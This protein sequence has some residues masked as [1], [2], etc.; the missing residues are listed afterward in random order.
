MNQLI[1]NEEFIKAAKVIFSLPSDKTLTKSSYIEEFKKLGIISVDGVV[2]DPDQTISRQ[3]LA[4]YLIYGLG[5]ANDARKV[6]PIT[7][8]SIANVDRVDSSINKFVTLAMQLNI[9]SNQEDGRFHGSDRYVTRA[10]LVEAA[11]EAKKLYASTQAEAPSKVSIAEVKVTGARKVAVTLNKI[12]DTEKAML[13]VK[14]DGTEL[15]GTT[16]WSD[17]RKTATITLD[18]KLKKGSYTIE[19]SGLDAASLD[20]KSAEFTAEDEQFKSLEFV[21]PSDTLARSKVI[22]AFKQTNQYGEQTDLV[23]SRFDI[24]VGGGSGPQNMTNKQEF[25]LDLS[26]ESRGARIP[27][28]LIDREHHVTVSKVFTVGDPAIVSK[29][30]V[31][32]LKY[33]DNKK[34]LQPGNKAYLPIKVYDQYGNRMDDP[35]DWKKGVITLFTGDHLIEEKGQ[36]VFYDFGDDGELEMELEAIPSLT[37]DSTTIL[38]LVA[39]GS[40]QTVLKRISVLTPKKPATLEIPDPPSFLAEGDTNKLLELKIRDAEGREFDPDERAELVKAGKLAVYSSGDLKLGS[41]VEGETG[42]IELSGI[43]KGNIRIQEVLAGNGTAS[44]E[45]K[46]TDIQQS[47]TAKIDLMP[48][49]VPKTLEKS[50]FEPSL[51]YTVIQGKSA[52]PKFKIMDQYGVEYTTASEDYQVEFKLERL[53]GAPGAFTGVSTKN[54]N[55]KLTDAN[56]V[57]RSAGQ[58]FQRARG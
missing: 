29:L 11:Y 25:K 1:T 18:L 16:E 35:E 12:V 48:K 42:P 17:D 23:A 19:L 32:E 21:N 22:V 33:K 46:L 5:L 30:E 44:I 45:V 37:R 13:T 14:Q 55:L 56:P 43:G 9:M 39:A 2:L 52:S 24:M 7:D 3:T 54:G 49:R 8:T 4:K 38:N 53:D 28:T 6:T 20:K 26:R 34:Y 41:M 51:Q 58:R 47:A 15:A 27:V 40:G 10:G 31:G 57:I 50:D 36:L